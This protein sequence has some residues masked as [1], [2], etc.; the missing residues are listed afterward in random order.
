MNT[1]KTTLYALAAWISVMFRTFS[2]VS[3]V[4]SDPFLP[5]LAPETGGLS[6]SILVLVP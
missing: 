2:R 5:L 6:L 3:I 1:L 4:S